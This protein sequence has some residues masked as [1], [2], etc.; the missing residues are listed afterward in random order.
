MTKWECCV[1][2]KYNP[3]PWCFHFLSCFFFSVSVDRFSHFSSTLYNPCLRHQKIQLDNDGCMML[4]P[5]SYKHQKKHFSWGT[6]FNSTLV[7]SFSWQLS[8]H[9][10][11]CTTVWQS[12]CRLLC[13]HALGMVHCISVCPEKIPQALSLHQENRGAG[14]QKPW[15]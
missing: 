14:R 4:I 1:G 5:V 2:I 3:L 15:H 7:C 13:R 9:L 12:F 6:H 11:K 10:K 8:T